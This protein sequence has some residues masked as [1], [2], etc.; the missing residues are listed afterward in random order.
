[1]LLQKAIAVKVGGYHN[2]PKMEFGRLFR[3][4]TG[5]PTVTVKLSNLKGRTKLLRESV[6]SEEGAEVYLTDS[7]GTLAR[8]MSNRHTEQGAELELQDN[9]G[10][11]LLLS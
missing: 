3:M 2:L 11:R 6:L 4:L 8:V 5:A 7:E 10:E 1:M 9:E